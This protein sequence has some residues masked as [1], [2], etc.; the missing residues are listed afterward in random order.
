MF[1]GLDIYADFARGPP[2]KF[3]GKTLCHQIGPISVKVFER[4]HTN[5]I[6]RS[7]YKSRM[8]LCEKFNVEQ[9]S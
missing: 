5:R 8:I 6:T 3:L 4:S 7:V 2:E 9:Y 1:H